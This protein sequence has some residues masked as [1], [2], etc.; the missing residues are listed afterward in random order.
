[1]SILHG[2]AV[3]LALR[4]LYKLNRGLCGP[5]NRSRYDNEGN[6]TLDVNR[7]LVVQS[8]FTVKLTFNHYISICLST[9]YTCSTLGALTKDIGKSFPKPYEPSGI[10]RF[11]DFQ[12]PAFKKK[13][14]P[15][16]QSFG[17][18][19]CFVLRWR[20]RTQLL[21]SD[22]YKQLT[23]SPDNVTTQ[24][25]SYIN[26]WDQD[27]SMGDKRKMC[28]QILYNVCTDLKLRQ[29]RKWKLNVAY[30]ANKPNPWTPLHRINLNLFMLSKHFY[31]RLT[32]SVG[33]G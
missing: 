5:T 11:L 14:A 18:W 9:N 32:P 3:S 21:C 28:S 29:K 30:G 8:K 1:M 4:T 6:S 2:W 7:I 31:L 10:A 26:T 20:G 24:N 12:R 19:I 15:K 23:Q 25:H 17:N 13:K 33:G 27:L 22:Y 16:T